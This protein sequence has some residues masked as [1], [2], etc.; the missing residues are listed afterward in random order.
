MK[1]RIVLFAAILLFGT[2]AA[3]A[4]EDGK[5]YK[6]G[7]YFARS[8]QAEF[9]FMQYRTILLKY[10]DSRYREDATFAMG[11]YFFAVNDRV[12]AKEKFT[13]YVRDFPEGKGKIFALAYLLKIAGLEEDKDSS[14]KLRNDIITFRQISLVFRNY[15]EYTYRSPLNKNYRALFLIDK[16][17]ISLQGAEFVEI[18][19]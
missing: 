7:L 19:Y 5:L 13:E 12:A 10:P 9:A 3:H 6:K 17:E 8:G 14:Q 16:I 11:E 18:S 1:F 4:G 15:K 2:P